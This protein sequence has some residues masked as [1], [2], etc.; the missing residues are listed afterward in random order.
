VLGEFQAAFSESVTKMWDHV[1]RHLQT[2]ADLDTLI[3]LDDGGRCLELIPQDIATAYHVVGV[4]QTTAGVVN[5]ESSSFMGP[6]ID[7]AT[8]AAKSLEA[9]MVAEVI[10]EKISHTLPRPRAKLFFGV[11]GVG[12][13]GSAVAEKLVS[14]GYQV[15]LYDIKNKMNVTVDHKEELK[16]ILADNKEMNDL[17]A[18]EHNIVDI[19]RAVSEKNSKFLSNQKES[20]MS[21]TGKTSWVSNVTELI[22]SS[23]YVFGCTGR[24]FTRS[25][26]IASII[27]GKKH[28]ISCSSEDKEFLSV[29]K[30]IQQN[31]SK[32]HFDPLGDIR[33]Q[34]N[35][36]TSLHLIKGGFPC[37]FDSSGTSV[38]AQQIQLTR[39]LILG[40]LLQAVI[41]FPSYRRNGI[42]GRIMLDP[43]MQKFLV[44]EWNGCTDRK[45][46][47]V[48]DF[49]NTN[50]IIRNSGGMVYKLPDFSS[51]FVKAQN[52]RAINEAKVHSM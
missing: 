32:L 28:F 10:L 47:E 36:S 5:L 40:G 20:L 27:K 50:W 29:L 51:Y 48:M 16:E 18:P 26:D 19:R 49:T 4:E 41:A 35:Q 52:Q 17:A 11:V 38:P 15:L 8:S 31:T 21:G 24:D 45:I 33:W 14:Q 22:Q 12:F 13:V 25:L 1:R 37:N 43:L 9:D 23:S 34:I 7:V 6:Y 39:A 44:S 46:N 3:V 2:N 30:Q 42:R